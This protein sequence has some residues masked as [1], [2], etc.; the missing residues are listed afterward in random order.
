MYVYIKEICLMCMC[1]SKT[2]V[3]C[4][5]ICPYCDQW[6]YIH[7]YTHPH[8]HT[9]IFL[10]DACPYVY[11]NSVYMQICA[12]VYMYS[13]IMSVQCLRMFL[14]SI[15][16]VLQR[17]AVCCS[18]LCGAVCCRVLQ[19]DQYSPLSSNQCCLS[20][21]IKNSNRRRKENRQ[22]WISTAL[23]LDIEISRF[24]E[25]RCIRIVLAPSRYGLP[26]ISRLL[27]IIGLFCKRAL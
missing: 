2:F 1:I 12:C 24:K 7:T 16:R 8:T 25:Q 17:I 13:Y 27:K 15:R 10:H 20:P 4:V 14:I 26:T 19:S 6:V 5:C 9:C 23:N 18:V 22:H 11:S 21:K 3:W